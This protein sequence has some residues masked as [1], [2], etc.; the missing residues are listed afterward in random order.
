MPY[1]ACL[2][3]QKE[4]GVLDQ[5]IDVSFFLLQLVWLQEFFEYFTIKKFLV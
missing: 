3:S 5:I 2:I 4:K 1:P